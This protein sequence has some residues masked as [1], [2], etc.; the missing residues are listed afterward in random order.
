[1]SYGFQK[2][3]IYT[4]DELMIVAAARE[5][6]AK[7]VIIV[8]QGLPILAGG[9]AKSLYHPDLVLCTEA[10]L[11]DFEPFVSP[12]H[13]ADPCCTKGFSASADL[14]D[15]FTRYTGRGFI[16][17]CF[18]G[19]AQIDR[20]G[21]VN[22]TATGPYFDPEN[23]EIRFPGA[24][25]NPDFLAYSKK[26]II[27]MRGGAFVNKLDYFTSPGYLTGGNSRYE[28]GMPEGTG[29][30]MVIT[31][32]AVFRFD[33][34]TKEIYL[35]ELFPGVTVEEIKALVPWE[36]KVSPDI[37]V[38]KPPTEKEV[39]WIRQFDPIS[40]AGRTNA[41]SVIAR[42]LGEKKKKLD[43]RRG[44][45]KEVSEKKKEIPAKDPAKTSTTLP[46]KPSEPESPKP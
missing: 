2:T 45:Q 32:N 6:Q 15:M 22:T 41:L 3:G 40:A 27:T 21:N 26:T 28:N 1:M 30:H 38:T 11:I 43:A 17:V 16:D 25:G 19:C 20:Y 14:I 4:R 29:P 42:A 7:E 8:G 34:I 46:P 39:A 18:L 12:Q 23:L 35:A 10:G 31:T 24:G 9:L 33:P 44:V 37:K 13:I 36:L 5:I